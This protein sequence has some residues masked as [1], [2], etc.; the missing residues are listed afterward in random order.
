VVYDLP[1]PKTGILGSQA[2]QG[3]GLS[4]LLT[5]QSGQPFTAG[6]G[7]VGGAYGGAGGTPLA[8]CGSSPV[9]ALPGDAPLATCTPGT[10][11]NPLAAQTSGPIHSRLDYYINP[12]FFSYPPPVAFAGDS[13]STGFGS[14]GMRNI[15]RGPF[16][17][18]VDFSVMKNFLIA[19]RHQVQF[20]TDFFKGR[21][22][23]MTRK[24]PMFLSGIF[25]VA[26]SAGSRTD[27]HR[28]QEAARTRIVCTAN[29]RCAGL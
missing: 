2:F 14:P 9:T 27:T 29:P 5:V 19:E 28:L 15:Y 12:N 11:T 17:E 7:F 26:F 10:P 8:V 23:D 4:G 16:Q 1:V 18:N 25:S 20:R 3:W 13:F 21:A 6:D 24:K 22:P